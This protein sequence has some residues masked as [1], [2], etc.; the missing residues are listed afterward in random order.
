MNESMKY[1]KTKNKCLKPMKRQ[2]KDLR[3][4]VYGIEEKRTG[5]RNY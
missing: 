2:G 5:N 4:S 1:N 3:I